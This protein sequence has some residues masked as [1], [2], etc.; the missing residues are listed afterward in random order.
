MRLLLVGFLCC[1]CGQV[2]LTGSAGGLSVP[3][4]LDLGRVFVGA[5]AVGAVT[6]TSE[7]RVTQQVSLR[8]DAPFTLEADSLSLAGGDSQPVPVHV[9]PLV[10]GA[11]HGVLQVGDVQVVLTVEAVTAPV[12]VPS[13]PCVTSVADLATMSCL[14]HPVD[15]GTACMPDACG[16]RGVCRASQCIVAEAGSCDDHN[17]CTL[18]ACSGAGG[19]VHL[20]RSASCPAPSE[21]CRV[22]RCDPS[23]G[24]ATEPA[25]DGTACGPNDCFNAQVCVAGQ[26]VG[27][28]PRWVQVLRAQPLP[29]RGH[30]PDA[31]VRVASAA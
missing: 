10:E 8:V 19:C 29:G 15:D 30:L 3:P 7:G 4:S 11:L 22:A 5:E 21:P 31:R 6:V 26:C 13:G 24:C 12:C 28:T 17:A 25:P 14:E 1:A 16:S 9:T 23:T 20:D 27:R 18:D 2:K